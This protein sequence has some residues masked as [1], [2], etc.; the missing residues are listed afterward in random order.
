MLL[1]ARHVL[2]LPLLVAGAA[3]AGAEAGRGLGLGEEM[4]LLVCAMISILIVS[5]AG[6]PVFRL[7]SLRPLI[8]PICLSC[9]RRHGNYHLD[10][11][12]WP[13]AVLACVHCGKPQ[14]LVLSAGAK[15]PSTLPTATLRW[16]GFLG[17]WK[18]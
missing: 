13:S 7:L 14:R 5:L 12:C 16:P 11:A 4:G 18:S 17:L 6:G 3:L 2:V 1:T 8:L 9:G 10:R 15:E